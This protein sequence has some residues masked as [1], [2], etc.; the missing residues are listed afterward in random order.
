M[1]DHILG[2]AQSSQQSDIRRIDVSASVDLEIISEASHSVAV[3]VSYINKQ[4]FLLVMRDD[5]N[6][7]THIVRPSGFKDL[8]LVESAGGLSG[9]ESVLGNTLRAIEEQNEIGGADLCAN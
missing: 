6:V 2:G 1:R 9:D 7:L 3:T 8:R 5:L 4:T